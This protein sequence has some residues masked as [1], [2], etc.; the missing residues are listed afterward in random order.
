M[1]DATAGDIQAGM[2]G[3]LPSLVGAIVMPL[4]VISL[5]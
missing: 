1:S 3:Y 5:G 4:D 2:Q